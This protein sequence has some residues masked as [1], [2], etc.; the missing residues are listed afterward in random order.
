MLTGATMVQCATL[1]EFG[2]LLFHV[3]VLCTTM[4]QKHAKQS[5]EILQEI[6]EQRPCDNEI[7]KEMVSWLLLSQSLSQHPALGITLKAAEGTIVRF[8][9]IIG[10]NWRTNRAR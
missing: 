5:F 8:E 10:H 1:K 6:I 7:C 4:Y 9:V 3:T 2:K